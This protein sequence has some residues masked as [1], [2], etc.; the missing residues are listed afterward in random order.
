M[1]T[2]KW[3][4]RLIFSIVAALLLAVLVPPAAGSSAA[5]ESAEPEL[6]GVDLI[7][8][9]DAAQEYGLKEADGEPLVPRAGTGMNGRGI[10]DETGIEPDYRGVVGYMSLQT[11]WEVSRFNTFTET[12]WQLPVYTRKGEDDWAITGAVQHKTPVLV[13]DQAI[14][15]G[16]GH[17]YSGYLQVIRLDTME[18]VWTDVT[19]FVTVP[20]WMLDLKE[21]VRYGYCVAVYRSRSSYDPLDR[22]R[23]RGPLPEGTRVLMCDKRSSRYF[24]PD[25]EHRPL[26]GI[27]FR[28]GRE[29]D[30]YFRT[31]LFFSPDD[32]T[33]IY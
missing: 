28:S 17:K 27:I 14:R 10:P 9:L 31:F 18:T 6:P 20:Y 1:K 32:L 25:K 22:K 2:G 29:G 5:A 3:P 30:S 12:P 23:H 11:N 4:D 21:A 15:E 13:V 16:K 33:L 19:Q 7:M 8:A 26:L 24:S